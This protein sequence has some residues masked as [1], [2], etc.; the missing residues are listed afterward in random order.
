VIHALEHA[1]QRDRAA[2]TRIYFKRGPASDEQIAQ[3]LDILE[4]SGA[5]A[6]AHDALREQID[7]ARESLGAALSL[8]RRL[9]ASDPRA[10]ADALGEFLAYISADAGA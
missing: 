9:S 2:L 4:R 6:R 8:A 5:R 7:R 10:S 3:A 1:D